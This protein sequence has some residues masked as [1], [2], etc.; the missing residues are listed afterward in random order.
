MSIGAVTQ[1]IKFDQPLTLILGCNLDL[2]GEE[3]A[4]RNGVGKCCS[5]N[6]VVRVR[7]KLTGEIKELTMGDL[8]NAQIEKK[9]SG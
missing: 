6:T 3:N 9:H 5:I 8:Y 7:N 2:G 1:S 4:S